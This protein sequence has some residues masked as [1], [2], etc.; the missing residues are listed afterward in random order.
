MAIAGDDG[1]AQPGGDDSCLAADVENLRA[2]SKYD[3]SDRGIA[4]E[5][6]HRERV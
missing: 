6:A 5:L 4:G 2:R 3:A 1:P